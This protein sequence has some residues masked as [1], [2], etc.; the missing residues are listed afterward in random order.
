MTEGQGEKSIRLK[1]KKA[2]TLLDF[3]GPPAGDKAHEYK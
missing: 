1:G 3:R 2:H